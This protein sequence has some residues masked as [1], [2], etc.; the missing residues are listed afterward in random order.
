MLKKTLFLFFA[1]N[2]LFAWK[3]ATCAKVE[4]ILVKRNHHHHHVVVPDHSHRIK[5]SKLNKRTEWFD[6]DDSNSCAD[7]GSEGN[8]ESVV[9]A[10]PDGSN[11]AAQGELGSH[12]VTGFKNDRKT[13]Q[14]SFATFTDNR[15]KEATV[16]DNWKSDTKNDN[17]AKAVSDGKG[18]SKAVSNPNVSEGTAQGSKGAKVNSVY[19]NHTN[20]WRDNWSV[21]KDGK[22]FVNARNTFGNDSQMKTAGRAMGIGNGQAKTVSNNVGTVVKAN[23][24]C[25]SKGDTRAQGEAKQFG[26]NFIQGKNGNRDFARSNTFNLDQKTNGGTSTVAKGKGGIKSFT[27]KDK[28]AGG[29][30]K[31]TKGTH[32]KAGFKRTQQRNADNWSTDVVRKRETV[33]HPVKYVDNHYHHRK[34][35][36]KSYSRSCSSSNSSE[37]QA[38]AKEAEKPK[39]AV[40][41]TA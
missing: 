38:P 20:D 19:D 30:A 10:G 34:P 41:T 24:D 32:N 31:G 35:Y 29:I 21:H 28:G 4:P 22:N 16:V 9:M 1:L 3:D 37:E 40:G 39:V 11:S 26:N 5:E 23:G 2:A 15:G 6:N 8:G 13:G 33:Y 14:K 7:A 18:A 17:K 36:R 12:S 27:N 25:L